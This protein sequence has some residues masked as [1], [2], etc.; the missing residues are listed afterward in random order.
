[1]TIMRKKN[2]LKKSEN[3]FGSLKKLSQIAGI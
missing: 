3:K 2:N 1:M